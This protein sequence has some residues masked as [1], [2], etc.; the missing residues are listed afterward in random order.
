MRP[1]KNIKMKHFIKSVLPIFALS[2]MLLFSSCSK[3]D[4]E[5][6][7]ALDITIIEKYIT[8]NGLNAK[9]TSTGLYYAI[10]YL[11]NGKY[12]NSNSQVLIRYRGTLV[13]GTLFDENW[14]PPINFK[15]NDVI[16]G[17]KQGIPLFRE[18]GIGMLLIPS[19]LGYGDKNV[20]NIPPNSVLI[21]EIELI[22]V[23]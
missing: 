22:S 13:D 23:Y 17:W 21:F 8:D 20:G 6:Q 14:N 19:G 4:S 11:G 3:D 5:E 9:S 7:L 12:P 1:S 10:D 2:G 16:Q 15:L 18:G